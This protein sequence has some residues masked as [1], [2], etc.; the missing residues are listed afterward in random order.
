V[1]KSNTS[2]PFNDGDIAVYNGATGN[3]IRSSTINIDSSSNVT[4]FNNYTGTGF[5]TVDGSLRSN[6]SLILEDPGIGTDTVTF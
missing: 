2:N 6:T 4:G 3:I 5:L 1:V